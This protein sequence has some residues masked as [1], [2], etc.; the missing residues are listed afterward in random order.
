MLW[1]GHLLSGLAVGAAAAPLLPS[2]GLDD[3]VMSALLG[4]CV[5]GS[6]ALV[7]DLDCREAKL[8]NALGPVTWLL[9][10]ALIWLSIAVYHLTKTPRDHPECDGHRELTHT[11]AFQAALA[12]LLGHAV[13]LWL[14]GWFWWVAGLTFAGQLAH[15]LGD[16]C[17]IQG[18]PLWWPLT[19]RGRRW[20][21]VGL[22]RPLRF[23]TGGSV[24]EALLTSFFALLLLAVALATVAGLH[25][26]W[27]TR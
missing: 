20:A 1:R 3:P 10:R 14:P 11:P 27:I 23:E 6:F 13:E 15:T 18:V 25:P 21:K 16:A 5:A 26:A 17:T 7:P 22:W 2:P 19:V 8:A 12:A 4:A 9:S 24:G